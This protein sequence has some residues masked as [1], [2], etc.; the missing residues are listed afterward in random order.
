MKVCKQSTAESNNSCKQ[1]K[2]KHTQRYGCKCTA[3]AVLFTNAVFLTSRGI[4][5]TQ[6]GLSRLEA[7]ERMIKKMKM[8]PA[9]RL[10]N[11]NEVEEL[12]TA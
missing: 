11:M 3:K 5:T 1:S 6:G 2:R 10:L 12:L 9:L 7:L 4:H 8:Q